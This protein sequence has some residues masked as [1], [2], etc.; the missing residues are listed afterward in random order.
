MGIG[1]AVQPPVEVEASQP[2]GIGLEVVAALETETAEVV[3]PTQTGSPQSLAVTNAV[4]AETVQAM[5]IGLAAPGAL[6]AE[7]AVIVAITTAV[8]ATVAFVEETET[9]NPVTVAAVFVAAVTNAL[10]AELVPLL[11]M[12]LGLFPAT[13]TEQGTVINGIR[14]SLLL[15]LAS[16]A[17]QMKAS[18]SMLEDA[19][20]ESFENVETGVSS[21]HDES[22]ESREPVT[23]GTS[24]RKAQK[25]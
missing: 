10:E 16:S 9:A 17:H 19:S 24:T 18:Q 15:I 4:E 25:I 11:S 22:G 1:L 21:E 14:E 8:Q 20:Y 7:L 2:I 5:G 6:E 13:E 23:S 3:D 12:G